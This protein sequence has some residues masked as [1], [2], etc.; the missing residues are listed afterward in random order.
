MFEIQQV[1]SICV[2]CFLTTHYVN[3]ILQAAGRY[4]LQAVFGAGSSNTPTIHNSISLTTQARS[5]SGTVLTRSA[6]I[7]L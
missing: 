7:L 6:I 1:Q 3:S 4:V 2:A 5:N